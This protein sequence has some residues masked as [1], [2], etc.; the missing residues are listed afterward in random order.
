MRKAQVLVISIVIV[1]IIASAILGMMLFTRSLSDRVLATLK[2]AT[3]Y[4]EDRMVSE[5]LFQLAV[6]MYA[7]GI[8]AG[9]FGALDSDLQ[10]LREDWKENFESLPGEKAKWF[11]IYNAISEGKNMLVSSTFRSVLES[12]VNEK[13]LPQDVLEKARVGVFLSHLSD[14][15]TVYTVVSEYKG[16]IFWANV[17]K[18][19]LNQYMF[20]TNDENNVNF[21]T[22]DVIDGPLY[23]LDTIHVRGSPVF[24]GHVVVGGIDDANGTASPVFENGYSLIDPQDTDVFRLDDEFADKVFSDYE[25][26]TKEISTIEEGD[27]TGIYVNSGLLL[28]SEKV[29]DSVTKIYMTSFP[30]V[31]YVLEYEN[32]TDSEALMDAT[33]SKEVFRWGRWGIDKVVKFK[34]NGL[35]L[36]KNDVYIGDGVNDVIVGGPITIASKSD[37]AILS[38]IVYSEL[39]SG[40]SFLKDTS[41]YREIME[42]AKSVLNLVAMNDVVMSPTV[43]NNLYITASIYA[44]KGEFYLQFYNW[45]SKDTLHIFGSIVQHTRGPIGTFRMEDGEPVK[46]TGFFKDYVYDKRLLVGPYPEGTPQ[47]E[48]KV[49]VVDIR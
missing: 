34:F 19:T 27:R 32:G 13:K 23:T 7:K 16:N 6:A 40:N 35:I 24:K 42:G 29:S 41:R 21:I 47:M 45:V 8:D 26:K 10:G 36:A 25:A 20:V 46:L 1:L 2:K 11:E 31:R 22:G 33:L 18:K 30:T 14:Y 12:L 43:P 37:I 4:Y 44:L 49:R 3:L 5:S 17:I 39:A 48:G 38:N 28:W 15:E 9:G